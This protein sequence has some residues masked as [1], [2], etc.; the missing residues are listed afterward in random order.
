MIPL[1]QL[2]ER[3]QQYDEVQLLEL[4]DISSEEILERFE[5]KLKERRSYIEKELELYSSADEDL[6]AD[7]ML[8]D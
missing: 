5:D 4:L 7:W 6:G 3:L 2:I 1:N 8:D